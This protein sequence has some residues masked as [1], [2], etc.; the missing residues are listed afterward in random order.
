MVDNVDGYGRLLRGFPGRGHKKDE[1]KEPL[2]PVSDDGLEGDVRHAVRQPLAG[3]PAEP[4]TYNCRVKMIAPSRSN[5]C[6]YLM[7]VDFENG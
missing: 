2:V 5:S 3:A 6:P 4:L 1:P 7:Y